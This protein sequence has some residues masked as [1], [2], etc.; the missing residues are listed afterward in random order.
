MTLHKVFSTFLKGIRITGNIFVAFH[1]IIVPKF[2]K[3]LLRKGKIIVREDTLDWVLKLLFNKNIKIAEY[4]H[5]ESLNDYCFNDIRSDDIILDIGAGAGLY[6][7]LSGLKAKKVYSIE[8]ILYETIAQF[9]KDI[10]NIEILSFAFG[11]NNQKMLCSYWNRSKYV[12]AHDI[13]YILENIDE[14]ITVVKCDCE[15]CEWGGFW[16]CND[17]K[18]I[19]IIDMEYHTNRKKDLDKFI[20]HLH[21]NGFSTKY[22]RKWSCLFKYVGLLYAEKG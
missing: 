14:K 13:R 2:E 1:E 19:R 21:K 16:N 12:S 15:G 7:M 9:T 22:T 6:S 3:E 17:F 8:P 20:I 4:D 18:N 11:K 10:N 5:I